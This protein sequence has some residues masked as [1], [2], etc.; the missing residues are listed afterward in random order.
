[1]L[2]STD[3]RSAESI[4]ATFRSSSSW[5]T[6]PRSTN[7]TLR[8]FQVSFSSRAHPSATASTRL[9][10]RI[11]S[12][13]WP[14]KSVT[15]TGHQ[16]SPETSLA[17]DQLLL[18]IAP[19]LIGIDPKV[20][21]GTASALMLRPS[22]RRRNQDLQVI[23]DILR[24]PT[25]MLTQPPLRMTDPGLDPGIRTATVTQTAGFKILALMTIA[26]KT[27]TSPAS[28]LPPEQIPIPVGTLGVN[29]GPGVAMMTAMPIPTTTTSTAGTTDPSLSPG[30]DMETGAPKST[31][32]AAGLTDPSPDPDLDMETGTPTTTT[33]TLA[34]I[35]T[36]SPSQADPSPGPVT[37]TETP[38]MVATRTGTT[39][40][41]PDIG[42]GTMAPTAPVA[43]PGITEVTPVI[44]AVKVTPTT[45][46]TPRGATEDG[47]VIGA[48]KQTLRTTEDAP[49][50]ETAEATST[51]IATLHGATEDGLA[52]GVV[53][54]TLLTTEKGQGIVAEITTPSAAAMVLGAAGDGPVI[55][56]VRLLQLSTEEGR[57]IVDEIRTPTAM[58][59]VPGVTGGGPDIVTETATLMATTPPGTTE[60]G[61]AIEAET[62]TPKTTAEPPGTIGESRVI[63]V[64][65]TTPTQA[66]TAAGMIDP[67]Q[68][69]GTGM[70]TTTPTPV[71]RLAPAPTT[72]PSA[73]GPSPWLDMELMPALAPAFRPPLAQD[74]VHLTKKQVPKTVQDHRTSH[75]QQPP[76][77]NRRWISQLTLQ[78]PCRLLT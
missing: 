69:L 15:A 13:I 56:A 44:E 72:S 21:T 23:V 14:R 32:M 54:A 41:G 28:D 63:E 49:G 7:G 35:P 73:A 11:I 64:E 59:M 50:I 42:P 31:P 48:V 58:A 70:A 47:P 43:Q 26:S 27:A 5:D 76:A 3:S 39:E 67:S 34:L 24:G 19:P 71:V 22:R 60:E 62:T 20:A 33:A 38:T 2:L 75:S 18:S 77:R 51:T 4:P 53:T 25:L 17:L 12:K 46:A 37:E 16:K 45:T 36:T 9:P 74:M 29:L 52:I 40:A 57:V 68:S 6:T 1:M 78:S 61:R 65:T 55:G 8:S 10:F 30:L 66:P